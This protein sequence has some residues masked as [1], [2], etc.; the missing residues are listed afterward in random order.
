[1]LLGGGGAVAYA[2]SMIG[3]GGGEAR[4]TRI[5]PDRIY[6][7]LVALIFLLPQFLQLPGSWGS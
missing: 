2:E 3:A 4:S 6:L 1:M 7:L 5:P